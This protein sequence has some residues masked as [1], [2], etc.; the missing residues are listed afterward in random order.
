MKIIAFAGSNSSAS[1]NKKLVTYAV[2][3]FEQDAIEILD[4]NEYEMP[5]YSMDREQEHGVP[6]LAK[7]FAQKIDNCD[8]LLV[9]LA[10]HNG[11]YSTAFKN[12]FDWVSRIAGRKVF[13]NKPMF[14]M[15][16]SPGVRGGSSVLDIAKNRFP[17]N[18]ALILG[19]FLL[20]SFHQNFDET[21]GITNESIKHQFEQIIRIL[22]DQLP[23][24][25]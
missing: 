9:S 15:A 22:K 10:E 12:I 3:F 6:Q 17:Y 18:G 2:S 19:T 8:L 24:E 7:S 25:Q 13:A 4:L 14:L 20:P 11:A 16:T 5:V 23:K 21:R 1:I